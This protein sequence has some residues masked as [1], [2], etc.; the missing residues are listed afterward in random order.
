MVKLDKASVSVNTII[1][2][3]VTAT[4]KVEVSRRKIK[5]VHKTI[6]FIIYGELFSS[7]EEKQQEE[8]KTLDKLH[9]NL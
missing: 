4:K 8:K 3:F 6:M 2:G 1:K 5:S 9:F 7:A